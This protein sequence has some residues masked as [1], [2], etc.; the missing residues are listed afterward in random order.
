MLLK[1]SDSVAA[2]WILC[3]SLALGATSACSDDDDDDDDGGESG[4]SGRGGS[5]GG[6]GRGGSG[7]MPAA[8]ASGEPGFSGAGGNESGG[9]AGQ[10]GTSGSAGEAGSAGESTNAGAGGGPDVFRPEKAEFKQE[11]F[12]QLRLAEGFEINVFGDGLGNARMLATHGPHVYLT[13]PMSGDVLLLQ[14]DDDDGVM[15]TQSSVASD[16]PLVHGIAFREN[17]VYLATPTHVYRANVNPTTGIFSTPVS[18]I[19][20][21]PDGGQH[22]L[23]TLG[24]GPVD[25]QLYISVG[26]SCDACPETNPE[27]A[28]IL[29]AALTG[30]SRTVVARGL[31]NTIGFGWHPETNLLWGM[32]HGSDFR[33]NDTP[34]E[35][36][37]QIRL[38]DDY[39]WPYC[40][41][42]RQVDP[43][44]QDPPGTTKQEYCGLTEPSVLEN[45]A[46][47][48]PIGM[49]FYTGTALPP[50]YQDDAFVAMHG[51]WN[52]FPPTGYSVRRVI[53]ED[54]EP[55]GFED[56]VGGFLVEAGTAYFGRPA[57]ITT[58]P[59][60]ALLFSD[61]VNGVIYRVTFAE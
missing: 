36:L 8:G 57:G 29:R 3:L 35:E 50:D 6:S 28:T 22:P 13:R 43:I 1:R 52:R 48:A 26:S 5:S 34:P 45:Q 18:I 42:K 41:G 54:G 32:D 37:N 60:G 12:D 53:F 40:F 31:R 27:H 7:G 15:D 2:C 25:D 38:G 20:D 56:I 21:L 61:D 11:Y 46:H 44:I 17:V 58:A 30:A 9:A 24:I 51:S 59:D 33:G 4:S 16:L 10:G 49:T 47:Q 23:R 55:Q 14:D 39:G 19:D